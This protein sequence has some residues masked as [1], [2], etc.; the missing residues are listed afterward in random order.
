MQNGG[1]AKIGPEVVA[2]LAKA[3][4]IVVFTGA[5]V[6][7]ESGLETFRGADGAWSRFRPEDLA[8]PEAFRRDPER[9]WRWYAERFAAMSRAQ[10]NPA[11]L[12]IAR[13]AQGFPSLVVV[14]QNVDGLHQR[15]GSPD[16]VE[17]HG[18]LLSSRCSGCGAVRPTAELLAAAPGRLPPA[19]CSCGA[20]FRPEVVWF[21]ELLPEAALERAGEECRRAGAFVSIGTSAMVWPAAGLI[22]I[23]ADAGALVVEI[24]RD[25]SA[26]SHLADATLL[27]AAGEIL[28]ELDRRITAWRSRA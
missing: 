3:D 23:A 13:W 20:L 4:R 6:S 15:A 8:T 10:P 27:G 14:T 18:S 7:Q 22:Q 21:G 11:H 28:P 26:L 16:V 24:N 19:P 1:V 12:S 25:P 9:V 2:R 5:G 17:L